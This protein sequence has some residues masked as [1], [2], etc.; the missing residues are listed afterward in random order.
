MQTYNTEII[1]IGTELLLGQ[2]ANTNAQWM[3]AELAAIGVNTFHHTVVGDNLQ[4]TVDTFNVAHERSNV[5]IVTGGLGP[6]EDDLTREAFSEMSGI[7]VVEDAGSRA[8]IERF[9]AKSKAPFS[10]NNLK[11]A[12]SL[13]G[14]KVIPN[15]V[16]MANGILIDYEGRIWIFLPGV[17]REMKAIFTEEVIPYL[18][19]LNGET[20]IESLV[21]KFIGIG[22]SAMEHSLQTLIKEQ[23]NPTIAPLALND[24]VT[25]RLTAKANTLD[26]AK[27]ML[28]ATKEK[29]LE[30]VQAY[31]YG[32][33]DDTIAGVVVALLA[34]QHKKIAAAESLTGGLFTNRLV[35]I[36]GV[37]DVLKG[38]VVCYDTAV[39]ENVL[40]I[41]GDILKEHGTVSSECALLMARNVAAKLQADIGISFTGV[42]GPTEIEGKPVGRVFIAIVDKNGHESVQE[43]SFQGNRKQVRYRAMLKGYEILF[44]Y[45]K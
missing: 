38:G 23:V 26:E 44:N 1:G 40:G 45:L 34:A 43:Y 31:Y 15:S 24:G 37:S 18:Q 41:S 3:S 10:P 6:T 16:G 14:A 20:I 9:F 30:K 13:E 12:N 29:V 25:L 4:R 11:Q 28:H 36:S 5:I 42:A 19:H 17:P 8:K 35:D 22:E 32:E 39:K 27:E 7:K 33:N 21:L 2:I